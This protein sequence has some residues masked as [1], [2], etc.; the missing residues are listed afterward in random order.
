MNNKQLLIKQTYTEQYTLVIDS[1]MMAVNAKMQ[2]KTQIRWDLNVL[3]VSDNEVEVKLILLDH[4]LLE[5]NNPLIKEVANLT[6]AFSR[7]YNELHL[8]IDQQGKILDVLNMDIILS[9]WKQTKAEMEKI[10]ENTPDIKNA[11]LLH[12]S[13]FQDKAKL[14]HGIQASE[15]FM[16]HFNY[17][18]GNDLPFNKKDIIKPNFFNSANV[19]WSCFV[20]PM[21]ELPTDVQSFSVN[22]DMQSFMPLGVGFYSRAYGQFANQIDITKLNTRLKESGTYKINPQT[23]KL[24]EAFLYREEVADEKQLFTKMQ[25]TLMSEAVY[26]ESIKDK[27][28]SETVGTSETAPTRKISFLADD[29]TPKAK[30]KYLVFN[31]YD[32]QVSVY[33]YQAVNSDLVDL[34][35]NEEEIT[36]L[37]PQGSG[38]YKVRTP[39]GTEGYIQENQ[40]KNV[41]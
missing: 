15:F 30:S 26:K 18:Y 4:I 39:K 27:F 19:Q 7:L 20:N 13:I 32:T 41:T 36:L 2:S 11:I 8:K 14:T 23:G 28:S 34:L 40:I 1:D 29:E 5:A 24:L 22:I 38:W 31:K 6:K 33:K 12:D 17:V 25:Y 35:K 37:E 9:K 21:H 10:A 16:L 3:K